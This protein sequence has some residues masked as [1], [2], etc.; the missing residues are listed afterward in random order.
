MHELAITQSILD[1]TL[2]EAEKAKAKQVLVVRVKIGALNGYEPECIK[3]YFQMLS[4]DTV[5]EKASLQIEMI[6][7]RIRCRDCGYTGEMVWY[8]MRCPDCQ[9]MHVE[10]VSG[11]EFLVESLDIED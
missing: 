1:V 2:S 7:A 8:R 4:E 10:L 6:P 9:G 5:A 3:E 11:K